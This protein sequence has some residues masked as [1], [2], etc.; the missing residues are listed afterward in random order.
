MY[1]QYLY[2]DNLNVATGIAAGDAN[3]VGHFM[4]RFAVTTWTLTCTSA[5]SVLQ[6]LNRFHMIRQQQAVEE[7]KQKS[8][9]GREKVSVVL[10][11]RVGCQSLTNIVH[12]GCTTG[13]GVDDGQTISQRHLGC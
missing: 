8:L 2:G 1:L 5:G 10:S 6:C 4:L 7:F 9:N 12:I 3:M 13:L 11:L